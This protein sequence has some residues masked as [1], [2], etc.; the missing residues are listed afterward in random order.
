[1]LKVDTSPMVKAMHVSRGIKWPKTER[2]LISG[3]KGKNPP[4][5]VCVFLRDKFHTNALGNPRIEEEWLRV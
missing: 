1:V 3:K 5:A 2:K 4:S